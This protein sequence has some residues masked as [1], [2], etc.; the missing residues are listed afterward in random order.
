MSRPEEYELYAIR[1]AVNDAR[2]R[3]Q[4]FILDA[5]PNEPLQL[6]FFSWVA[7]GRERTIVID[8]GMNR[9]AAEDH[10]HRF[11]HCP[12]D[13]L[14]RLGVEPETTAEVVLTH[15]HYDHIGNI[16]KFP[17]AR[18]HLHDTEM[19]FATGRYMRYPHLRRAYLA[20]EIATV[21]HYVHEGRVRFHD[22]D[23][24]IAPG[25]TVHWAGGHTA[26]QEFVRVR[27][28]RGW[29]VLA[30]DV[31]HYYEEIERSVPFAVVYD[32][33]EMLEGHDAMRA[34]ADSPDHIVPGHD[35]LIMQRY[36]A[37][38]SELEGIA[39]RL[40]MEPGSS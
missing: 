8:T 6:D 2:I 20:S 39:I 17:Q 28:R 9:K 29:V 27:T 32:V 26:G 12:T 40:D 23:C 38:S 37:A 33:G 1:Y 31:I 25:I 16:E 15:L 4:N 30:S 11:L 14:R 7:I 13:V 18:F 34:R 19:A 10:G 5:S 35:P 3:G 21:V 24:E 36:P 22:E